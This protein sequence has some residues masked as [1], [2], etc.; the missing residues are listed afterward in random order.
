MSKSHL[1]PCIS[2][3]QL[4]LTVWKAKDNGYCYI[5]QPC[6]GTLPLPGQ[7]KWSASVLS[8][9][10]RVTHL[11]RHTEASVGEQLKVNHADSFL[12]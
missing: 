3:Q 9:A 1:I 4:F 12:L 7:F 2:L 8:C 5:Q 10:W 11:W 6:Y